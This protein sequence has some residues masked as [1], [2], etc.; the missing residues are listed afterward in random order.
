MKQSH[1]LMAFSL[2]HKTSHPM[3]WLI[4]TLFSWFPACPAHQQPAQGLLDMQLA[5]PQGWAVSEPWGHV[6]KAAFPS[7]VCA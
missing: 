5:G 4:V 7:G 6:G 3:L 1:F 2:L